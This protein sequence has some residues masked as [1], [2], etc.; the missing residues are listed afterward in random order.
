MVW[1]MVLF[2]A[3]KMNVAVINITQ[4]GGVKNDFI[5]NTFNC[6]PDY[7]RIDRGY[8]YFQA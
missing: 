6:G 4:F 1:M 8:Q 7:Y 2:V 5:G 3:G